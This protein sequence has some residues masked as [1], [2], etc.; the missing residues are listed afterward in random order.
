MAPRYKYHQWTHLRVT[1]QCDACNHRY[2]YDKGVVEART[3]TETGGRK[4]CER[5]LEQNVNHVK[6]NGS[7]LPN[8]ADRYLPCP[9]CKYV[10]RWMAYKVRHYYEQEY[11]T[12]KAVMAVFISIIAILGVLIYSDKYFNEYTLEV[13][14]LMVMLATGISV[15]VYLIAQAKAAATLKD[16][17]WP[18]TE[19]LRTNNIPISQYQPSMERYNPNAPILMTHTYPVPE[20]VEEKPQ[21]QDGH[22][23]S[24]NPTTERNENISKPSKDSDG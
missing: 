21:V 22:N 24:T 11:A 1:V 8:N 2:W 19:W 14:M 12:G 3:T 15:T 23:E 20:I 4:A 9:K 17:D 5:L 6:N 13:L 16:P 10:S 18:N 7:Y